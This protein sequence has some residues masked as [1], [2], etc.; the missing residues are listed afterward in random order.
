MTPRIY[1]GAAVAASALLCH[2]ALAENRAVETVHFELGMSSIDSDTKD[3]TSNGTLGAN[4]IATLP[5]GRYFGL[6]LGGRYSESSVRTRDVLEDDSGSLPGG[7]PSCN[8]DSYGGDASLFFRLPTWGRIGA[9][10]GTGK[11][12]PDCNGGSLFPVTGENTL[13]TEHYRIDAEYYLGDF[14]FGVAH[15]TTTLDDG[16]EL[17][18]T[19]LTTSWYPLDSLKIA[20]SGHD[21]YDENTYGILVEHQ[22]EMLG[23]VLSVR[24][25]YSMTEE[26]PKTRTFQIGLSYYFGREVS[27][28]SRDRQYR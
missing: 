26:S 11:L 25:G 24:L 1:A 7:R 15:T 3:S 13:S 2:S 21:L 23:D 27:L 4:L 18:S 16:P 22:P 6:S 12:S 28:K 8:F 10:Y 5:L 17:E 9:S 14:T 20:L 19:M